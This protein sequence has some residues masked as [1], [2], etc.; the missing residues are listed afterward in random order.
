MSGG[1]L[2]R[3]TDVHVRPDG[4]GRYPES[5]PS[6]CISSRPP[7]K[8]MG[9]PSKIGSR[10]QGPAGPPKTRGRSLKNRIL[11]P[12]WPKMVP[13]WPQDGP[14]WAQDAPRWPKMAPRWLQD[15]PRWPKMAPKLPQDGSKMAQ[16]RPR[17]PQDG[18][19]W[20]QEGPKTA[21]GPMGGSS[22]KI[23]NCIATICF[24]AKK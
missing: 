7:P 1:C 23:Y 6:S 24:S 11:A 14:R 22:S 2:E 15:G 3:G 9:R 19:R 13:R 18:P 5:N 21:Y 17:W 16:D 10:T 12:R 4:F 8:R 20:L